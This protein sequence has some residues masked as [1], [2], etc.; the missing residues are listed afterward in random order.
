MAGAGREVW[1][2]GLSQGMTTEESRGGRSRTGGVGQRAVA[3]DGGGVEWWWQAGA[4]QGRGRCCR[5]GGAAPADPHD[6]L[7][8]LLD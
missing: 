5:R 3:G 4:E 6:R 8:F 1:G 2:R 7:G